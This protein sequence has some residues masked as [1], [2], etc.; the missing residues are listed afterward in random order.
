MNTTTQLQTIRIGHS[1]DSDDAFMFHATTNKKIDLEGIDFKHEL[2][3]IQTLNVWAKEGKLETTAISVHAYAFVRDKYAVLT[4]GASM[5]GENYGP[6]LVV[7]KENA[8]HDSQFT[9]HDWENKKFGIPGEMTSAF[10][11]LKLFLPFELKNYKVIP[12]KDIEQAVIDGVVDIGLLIHEGQ[13][14]HETLGLKSQINLG[15]WWWQKTDGLPLPLGVNVVRKDLGSDLMQKCSRI[16]KRSIQYALDN[17]QEALDYAMIYAR[18]LPKATA[19]KFVGMYVNHWTLD[20]GAKGK[21]SIELFLKE[22]EERGFIP[23]QA[24]VEFVD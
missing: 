6:S 24:P 7:K 20:M 15:Q 12:F 1:P 21:Q 5:G 9:T 13:L 8:I 3:D 11:A 18:E 17:R 16:M 19:D 14:T 2:H 23:R 4:H 10:L 22:A